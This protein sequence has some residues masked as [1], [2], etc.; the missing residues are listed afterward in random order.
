MWAYHDSR[1]TLYRNPYGTAPVGGAVVL[2][3][4]VGGD[5]DA[6]ATLRTWVDG[7]G[8]T[9]VPMVGEQLE[10]RVRFSVEYVCGQPALVRYSFVIER[11]DGRVLRYGARDGKT[12]GEGMLCEWE[13]PSFQLTVYEPREVKPAWFTSGIVYQI[14]PDRYRRGADWRARVELAGHLHE[15]DSADG[16]AGTRR[17]VVERWDTEPAYAKDEAGR[18]T[19]WDFYGGTL[20]GIRDD[21]PRLADMGISTLYLNPIFEARS[22]HRYDTADFMQVVCHAWRRSRAFA[23]C[24]PRLLSWASPSCSTASSTT[25]AQTRATSTATRP[26][27]SRAPAGP[28]PGREESLCRLVWL[29]GRRHLRRLVGR[30]RPACHKRVKPRL[31]AAHLRPRRR[32]ASL[33]CRGRPRLAPRR[34][35]RASRRVHRTD[36][37]G[38]RGRAPRRPRAGRGLGGRLQQ[39]ELRKAPPLPSGKRARLGH[40]LSLPRNG[41]LGFLWGTTSAPYAAESLASITENYPL[42]AQAASLNLLSS[43]DRPRLM[44]VLG[45]AWATPTGSPG[46]TTSRAASRMAS[47]A[48]PRAASGSRPSCR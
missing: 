39:G 46:P 1:D 35:G 18:V 43:H 10:D 48:L 15:N 33:A 9:F 14:F 21:L 31:P 30:R 24:V 16:V 42:E 27:P 22:S 28:H 23:T 45:G 29:E 32:G 26:M 37:R 20:E 17:N 36:P 8:E 12:G 19:T 5:R 2:K 3:L 38:R 13:P 11:G 41:V 4:D 7:E 34:G 44:S 25:W 47:V 6:S 40:E